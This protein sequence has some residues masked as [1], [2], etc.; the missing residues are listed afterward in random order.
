MKP[1]SPH[2]EIYKFPITAVSSITN[3]ITGVALSCM[4]VSGGLLCNTP[5]KEIVEEKYKMLPKCV[6]SVIAFPFIYH[7]LGGMRHIIWDKYPKLLTTPSV[8]KSSYILFGSS[9]IACVL[10]GEI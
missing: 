2:V 4:F 6:N 7:T 5:V 3:R 1:L 10:Y 8:S 9:I